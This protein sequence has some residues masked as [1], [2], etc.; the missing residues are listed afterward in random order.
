M[1]GIDRYEM[2]TK[3]RAVEKH[4]DVK[5]E[6]EARLRSGKEGTSWRDKRNGAGVRLNIR[7]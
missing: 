2:V 4:D 1:K 3:W 5:G 6:P 7:G